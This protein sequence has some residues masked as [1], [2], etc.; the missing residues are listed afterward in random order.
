MLRVY[1]TIVA[2]FLV[3]G[4]TSWK[5]RVEDDVTFEIRSWNHDPIIKTV[6]GADPETFRQ[7]GEGFGKDK[8]RVFYKWNEIPGA[9]PATFEQLQWAYSKDAN[10]VY[11]FTCALE[12]ARPDTFT[13]LN[14]SWSTDGQRVYHGHQKVVADAASFRLIGNSW[15]TDESNAYHALSWVSLGCDDNGHLEV[16]VFE[17]IDQATFEVIDA[18]KAKDKSGVYNAL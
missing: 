2:V 4:C 11:L 17:N 3:S 16:K 5:Y 1:L 6:A 7:I 10:R 8:S 18:F 12:N 9:D 13:L 14:D 15:A